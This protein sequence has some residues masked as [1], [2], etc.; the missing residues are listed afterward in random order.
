[1]ANLDFLDPQ[2]M[3]RLQELIN[4]GAAIQ[5]DP[6]KE[7]GS[8]IMGTVNPN[9]AILPVPKE[10]M[11]PVPETAKQPEATLPVAGNNVKVTQ[12]KTTPQAQSQ[13]E[14][15]AVSQ[16]HDTSS[17]QDDMAELQKYLRQSQALMQPYIDAEKAGVAENEQTLKQLQETPKQVDLSALMNY[18]DHLTGG[19][20]SKGYKAPMSEE[21]RLGTIAKLQDMIQGQRRGITSSM[22]KSLQDKLWGAALLGRDR[23]SRAQNRDAA[24]FGKDIISDL[25]KDDTE[26]TTSMKELN[27]LEDI[28]TEGNLQKVQAATSNFARQI[29]DE[30]GPL[31]NNDIAR[32]MLP[33]LEKY[34]LNAESFLTGKPGNKRL[35]PEYL[36]PLVEMVRQAKVGNKDRYTDLFNTKKM[37]YEARATGQNRPELM[38]PGA[39]FPKMFDER[40][41]KAEKFINRDGL[42]K[43]AHV[44]Q[45][46]WDA[47]S[48][49]LKKILSGAGR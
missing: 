1:M 11:M 42:K 46:H 7:L 40:I 14:A 24:Q 19:N 23:Q 39:S 41:K 37:S 48:D 6:M 5:R 13:L 30:K 9:A 10:S 43:P 44:A 18:A 27:K 15:Q 34:L 31:A 38:A 16:M 29:N 35:N 49:E 33:S 45:E 17:G 21:E 8:R 32:T 47:A 4:S 22:A 28:F 20:I 3:Q 25:D 12:P 26:M 36:K 2:K